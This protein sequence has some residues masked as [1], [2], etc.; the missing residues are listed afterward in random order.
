MELLTVHETA[1]LLKVNPMTIRR[2]IAQGRLAAVRV[3]KGVRVS[4]EALDRF[5]TP[6]EP[7]PG[8]PAQGTRPGRQ[9]TKED[10]PR[11]I[12]PAAPATEPAANA[13]MQQEY[14]DDVYYLAY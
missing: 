1:K 7:R 5:V 2:Y 10:Y 9:L 13:S 11:G 12:S 14:P 8:T 3:G 4:T 6:V